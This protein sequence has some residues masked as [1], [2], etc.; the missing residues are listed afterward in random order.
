MAFLL[1]QSGDMSGQRIEL[2]QKET[3]LGRAPDNVIA[4]PSGAVSSHHLKILR[5]ENKYTLIDLDSTNGTGLNGIAI[6]Q[7]RL[8]PRDVI[9]VGGIEILFDGEGVEI[10]EAFADAAT[11]PSNTV[12]LATFD[13]SVAT[14]APPPTF[15]ARREGR[16]A[17][18]KVIISISIVALAVLAWFLFR[19]IRAGN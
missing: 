1:I 13:P 19:L 9:S 11:G 6:K 14:A 7:A 5:E 10:D 15:G 16:R 8:K 3:S 18:L 2:D 17:W 4:I 12:R